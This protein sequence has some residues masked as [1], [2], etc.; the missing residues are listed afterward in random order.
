[1]VLLA[2][3]SGDVVPNQTHLDNPDDSLCAMSNED[4]ALRVA[5]RG[6]RNAANVLAQRVGP[7]LKV[8]L[9]KKR[10]G[11][12]LK[13]EGM[14]DA[15]QDALFKMFHHLGSSKHDETKS[16]IWRISFEAWMYTVTFHAAVDVWKKR[17][18]EPHISIAG[19]AIPWSSDSSDSENDEKYALEMQVLE[20]LVKNKLKG[21]EKAV[22]IEY[23]ATGGNLDIDRL[24]RE[25]KVKRN[26]VDQAKFKVKEKFR[27][28]LES[29]RRLR[30]ERE[31]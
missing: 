22:G 4:L 29:V 30:H 5:F 24:M 26:H 28:A 9:K 19:E 3:S 25:W 16:E 15:V 10:F 17:Q 18:E 6:D 11:A 13:E 7:K 14:Q 1:L 20:E 31:R 27:N 21:F 23:L 2:D 8:Y 12:S